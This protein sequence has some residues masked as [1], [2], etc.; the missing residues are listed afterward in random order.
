MAK[1]KVYK[2]NNG[3]IQEVIATF[4]TLCKA[5]IYCNNLHWKSTDGCEIVIG[6]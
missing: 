2:V 4:H 3:K 1:Y 6:I 5:E